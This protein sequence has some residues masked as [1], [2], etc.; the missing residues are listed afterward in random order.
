MMV[1]GCFRVT[2][3]LV[4]ASRHWQPGLAF[5]AGPDF[6]R[7]HC[8]YVERTTLNADEGWLW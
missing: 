1:N 8:G 7:T 5:G 6:V 4:R 3:G 2:F